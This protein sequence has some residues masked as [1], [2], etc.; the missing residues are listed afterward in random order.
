VRLTEYGSA[1]ERLSHDELSYLLRFVGTRPEER[2]RRLFES[3]MPTA[4]AGVY[5]LR[6]GPFVGRLGLPGGRSIDFESRFTFDDVVEL[7]RF[8][9]HP[10]LH[11]DLLRVE[12]EAGRGFI[13]VLAAAFVREVERLVGLGLGKGYRMRRFLRPPYPGQIDARYH[14]AQLGARKDRL[15]TE[16]KR[17]TVNVPVNQALA[18][19]LEVLRRV[20]LSQELI[21]RLTRLAACLRSVDRPTMSAD[22]VARI[23]LTNLTLSYRGALGLA[24]V[25]L[26]SLTLAPRGE[27]VSGASILFYMPKVWENC[28]RSWLEEAWPSYRVEGGYSFDLTAAGEM[29]SYADVV[30]IDG[31]RLVALYDAKYKWPADGPSASDVYQMV[32]Y[33][34]RLGL[35]EATLVYPAFQET[36][37]YRVGNRVIRTVGLRFPGFDI[38]EAVRTLRPAPLMDVVEAR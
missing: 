21:P 38:E 19:A 5:D 26:R 14:L 2:E 6:A 1:R 31:T 12:S 22:D 10:P 17:L 37:E 16:A 15:A 24:E 33:C 30:V 29:K 3:I 18:L 27:D 11:R 8:S 36:R 35:P 23:P 13:D 34:E 32:T 9:S 25:I 4:E 7:I 28:V 20:P